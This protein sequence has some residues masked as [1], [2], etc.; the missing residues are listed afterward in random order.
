MS[1]ISS[2]QD[3]LGLPPTPV[4]TQTEVSLEVA[5]QWQLMWWKFRKHRLAVLGGTVV[6]LFYF[7]AIF[8][9][10]LAP[11]SPITYI[12]EYAYAPPQTINFFRDG[13]FAPYVHGYKFERDPV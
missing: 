1:T 3:A 13:Q 11:V 8:A 7:V 12:A 2:P 5:S 6:L 10:F 9:D 4:E